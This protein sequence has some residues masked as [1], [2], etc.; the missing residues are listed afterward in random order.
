MTAVNQSTETTPAL[1][2]CPSRWYSV[3]QLMQRNPWL[4]KGGIRH[5]IFHSEEFGIEDAIMRP[6]GQRKV[7]IHEST[8]LEL[9]QKNQTQEAA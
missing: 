8:W 5:Q 7:L 4:T 2:H 6:E 1:P 3:E 9:L